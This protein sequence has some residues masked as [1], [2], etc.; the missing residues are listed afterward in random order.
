[1]AAFK[2]R[3]EK[4]LDVRKQ[5]E[6]ESAKG[7]ADA[8]QEAQ[9]ARNLKE[10]LDAIRDAGVD[11]LVEAH[12]AG[13][14]IGHLRNLQYLVS[15]IEERIGHAEAACREAETKVSTSLTAFQEAF[16]QRKALDHL[17]ERKL[18]QWRSEE[19]RT[20]RK[21]LDE[22]ALTRHARAGSGHMGVET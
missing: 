3:L 5:S 14:S 11:R 16:R 12:G 18:D 17:K 21:T 15:K 20:E 8:R 19:N 13:G 10:S 9:A 6:L 1:M 2:F 22:A 7:L 4:V